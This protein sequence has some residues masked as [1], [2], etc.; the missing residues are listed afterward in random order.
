MFINVVSILLV[1]LLADWFSKKEAPPERLILDKLTF[2]NSRL[3]LNESLRPVT[4]DGSSSTFPKTT[5]DNVGDF[6][7]WKTPSY[8]SISTDYTVSANGHILWLLQPTPEGD[9]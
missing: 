5:R 6:R 3:I 2:T 7:I 9:M 4:D 1:D 8:L